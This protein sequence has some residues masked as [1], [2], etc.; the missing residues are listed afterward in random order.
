[1]IIS[2]V[3]ASAAFVALHHMINHKDV[4]AGAFSPEVQAALKTLNVPWSRWDWTHLWDPWHAS[5]AYQ[6]VQRQ[7]AKEFLF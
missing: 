6:I 7:L 3:F 4:K 1:M 2:L 5:S